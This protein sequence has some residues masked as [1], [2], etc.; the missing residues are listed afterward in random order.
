MGSELGETSI[1]IGATAE[2]NHG[3]ARYS[4]SRYCSPRRCGRPKNLRDAYRRNGLYVARTYRRSLQLV[5]DLPGPLSLV[6]SRRQCGHS[7][8]ARLTM[9]N[10][11]VAGRPTPNPADINHRPAVRRAGLFSEFGVV[12]HRSFDHSIISAA[13]RLILCYNEDNYGAH[14]LG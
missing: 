8:V 12:F 11:G 6:R 4:R 1:N 10:V 9:K 3:V 2:K 7:R 13:R 14:R 5:N